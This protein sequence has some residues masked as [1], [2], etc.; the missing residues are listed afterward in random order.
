MAEVLQR[1]TLLAQLDQAGKDAAAEPE[2]KQPVQA[3]L[4]VFGAISRQLAAGLKHLAGNAKAAHDEHEKRIAALEER[5]RAAETKTALRY[6][7]TW[8]LDEQ[9]NPGELVTDGGSMWHCFKSTRTR[10]GEVSTDWALAVKKGRDGR[11]GR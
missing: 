1:E 4:G 11:D 9:Y 8:V 3:T 5:L 10:P 2:A 6:R 7:G